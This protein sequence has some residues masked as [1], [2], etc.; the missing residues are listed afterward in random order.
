VNSVTAAEAETLWRDRSGPENR[1][2][3]HRRHFAAVGTR[4]G[5]PVV[6]VPSSD[7]TRIGADHLQSWNCSDVRWAEKRNSTVEDP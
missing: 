7:E 1:V 2:L 5:S 3:R 6:S 4:R